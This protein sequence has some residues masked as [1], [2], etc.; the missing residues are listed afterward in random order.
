MSSVKDI[1]ANFKKGLKSLGFLGD[2][3]LFIVEGK[4]NIKEPKIKFLLETATEFD[5][6]AIYVRQ[7]LKGDY[8]IQAFIYDYT[9][10]QF[11]ETKN[12]ELGKIQ[13][14]IWS[15]GEAP[16]ACIFFNTEIKILDCTKHINEDY[17]PIHL[18]KDLK[19]AG[20]ALKLYD[21][22]FAIKIKSGVFWDAEENKNNFK[23]KNSSYD[24]LIDNI[25]IVINLFKKSDNKISQDLLNKIIIQSILIKFLEE[26]IDSDGKKLL[27]NKFFKKYDNA[28]S[29]IDVLKKRKF[30]E[31]LSDL[32]D[33][34]RGFNGNVFHWTL[35]EQNLLKKIDLNLLADLLDTKRLDLDSTQI[36]ME[37]PDWRY[38]DFKYI[39]VELISRLYEEFLAEGKKVKG[40]YYTPSHLA[41]LLVDECI[42]LKKYKDKD[43]DLDSFTVLDPA[44]G[45]G[46]FLVSVFKRLVQI[47]RLQNQMKSPNLKVLKKILKNI[48]GVDKEEQ[49]VNLASFS[50]CLALC[51][52][53]DPLDIITNLKF[54]DLKENNII[55]S[56][57]F[58][59]EKIKAKRFNLVIGNPPF[60][61][62][63]TKDFANNTSI[64]N[65]ISIGIPNNQIALKFLADSYGFLKPIG[66]QCLIIKSSGLLY[67]STSNHFRETLFSNTNVVQ[68]FDFTPLAEGKSLWDNG[69]RVGAAAIFIRN[70]KPNFNTNILHLTFRRTI[71]TRE[72]ILFEID[73]YD[74]HFVNRAIAINNH[75]IWKINLLGGG[76]IKTLIDKLEN[77]DTFKDFLLKNNCLTQ[78]GHGTL[79]SNSSNPTNIRKRLK[80]LKGIVNNSIDFTK[81]EIISIEE[82]KKIKD[83]PQYHKPA[84]L[85]SETID[86]EDFKINIA[87]NNIEGLVFKNRYIGVSSKSNDINFL[88]KLYAN[89]VE[90]NK[91]YILQFF[92]KSAQALINRN[93][94][95]L[96]YDLYN[97]KYVSKN[98]ISS[99]DINVSEDVTNY[100]QEYLRLGERA[101]A[102]KLINENIRDS[103]IIHYGIEFS[104]V[105]NLIYEDKKK[106]FRLSDIVVLENS[107]IATIFKYD[108][109]DKSVV[110]HKDN[111][112]LDLKVLTNIEIS[113]QLSI[114]RIIKLYPQKDT[115]IFIKPNQY[116]N[117]LSLIA[118][119]DADKCFADLSKLGY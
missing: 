20:D 49:A 11:S 57:F 101:K 65:D 90:F 29:F 7:Q 2:D 26:R 108:S 17:T 119:R 4:E 106:K 71:A 105:L 113:K 56:D 63:G 76:R 53:L 50:L 67:N 21:E 86:I 52:E 95:I 32:N 42:P 99:Y 104:K 30:V 70:D 72:R 18:V 94:A 14:K 39:P 117:W 102:A 59:C 77:Q 69:A 107:F 35:D 1:S 28:N 5:A 109:S 82:Q 31:L 66:L 58:E 73:D 68:I 79:V 98:L 24:K 55:N 46:I 23:F 96:A 75:S 15:S 118:Y 36:E 62:G 78:E 10:L 37:F 100:L 38:F 13:K 34:E 6:S 81:I 111:S 41:K 85:I 19:I 110:L 43:F 9:N 64:I 103:F 48:F 33:N 8:K 92:V 115:I 51:T 3:A 44:C 116:R 60:V 12:I 97:L 80:S 27:S 47:W 89:F 74:L 40:L 54:D 61:R 87:V 22:Q 16:I 88:K 114:N 91:L 93:T 25:R 45:S 112:K 83:I 84:L